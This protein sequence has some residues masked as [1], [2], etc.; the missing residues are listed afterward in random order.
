ME[1]QV[2]I[3]PRSEEVARRKAGSCQGCDTTLAGNVMVRIR[4]DG[5]GNLRIEENWD[6][7]AGDLIDDQGWKY[8]EWYSAGE[9][10]DL[11]KTTLMTTVKAALDVRMKARADKSLQYQ[12]LY[13]ILA[14][15]KDC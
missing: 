15:C 2:R 7:S 5:Q 11:K 6:I 8:R 4:C 1:F 12:D 14:A 13:T 3:E 9:K 10:L